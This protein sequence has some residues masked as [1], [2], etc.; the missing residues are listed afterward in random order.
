MTTI[1]QID[2]S[3]N[4]SVN[5]TALARIDNDVIDIVATSNFCVIYEFNA[6]TQQWVRPGTRRVRIVSDS[7]V[8]F[9]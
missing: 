5:L 7:T 3:Q 1:L 4:A 6:E 8:V 9:F 2:R